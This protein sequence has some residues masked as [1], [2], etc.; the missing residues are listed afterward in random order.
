MMSVEE[1]D[2]FDIEFSHLNEEDKLIV[3]RELL[4]S[5]FGKFINNDS[6]ASEKRIDSI[7][8]LSEIDK[9]FMSENV[10]AE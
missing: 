7:K 9:S 5:I 8:K 1:K 3:E 10:L 4:I 2:T 6:Q